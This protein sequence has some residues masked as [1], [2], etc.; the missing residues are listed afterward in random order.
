[1]QRLGLTTDHRDLTERLAD[2]WI[3]YT[4]DR[5][6]DLV[7]MEALGEVVRA[8]AS[9]AAEVDD[10]VRYITTALKTGVRSPNAQ[11]QHR[12]LDRLYGATSHTHDDHEPVRLPIPFPTHNETRHR[13]ASPD[14]AA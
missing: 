10:N 2:L 5:T 13:G 6:I 8:V 7:E 14:D 4:R 9:G 11:R 12:D 1:M 3:A